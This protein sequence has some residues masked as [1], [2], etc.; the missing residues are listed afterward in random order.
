MFER[1]EKIQIIFLSLV[2]TA[3]IICASLI[4][5]GAFSKDQITVTGSAYKIVKSDNARLEIE[6]ATKENSKALSYSLAQKQI[7][8]VKE[9]LK[10]KGIPEE[11]IELKAPHG[12]YTYKTLPNGNISNEIS[13]YNLSQNIIVTSNDV[14][15]IKEISTEIS[16]LIEKGIDINVYPPAYFY[17]NLSDLKIQLLEDATK[18]AK[19]RA[20]AMLKATN[21]KVGKIQ[22][23]RAGVFQ[24]TTEDSTNVS[25][26]GIN[27]TTTINK[28]VTSVAN[29]VFRIK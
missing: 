21:N 20:S 26:Y 8:V 3:G 1:L 17:S 18:D 15:K 23:V 22:S 2:L 14:Y 5:T 27:D 7:P 13:R 29:V 11:N 24:I 19:Q 16:S 12:Y 10:A 4:F 25:D 9:F 28:K 6:I